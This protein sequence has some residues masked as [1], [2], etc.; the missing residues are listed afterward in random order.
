MIPDVELDVWKMLPRFE[1]DKMCLLS[2]GHRETVD[3]NSGQLPLH[4]LYV[5]VSG[6]A[7]LSLEYYGNLV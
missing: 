3:A 6:R 7:F 5:I 4:S 1:I 2:E